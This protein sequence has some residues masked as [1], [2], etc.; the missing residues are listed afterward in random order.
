M[1]SPYENKLLIKKRGP[2]PGMINALLLGC[3]YGYFALNFSGD[4]NECYANDDSDDR[5]DQSTVTGKSLSNTVDVG[6][7]FGLTFKILFFMTLMECAISLFAYSIS[8]NLN[9]AHSK[10]V[11]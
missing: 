7:V 1:R 2:P 11:F 9:R 10:P 4:P 8:H 6:A 3:M 5:I